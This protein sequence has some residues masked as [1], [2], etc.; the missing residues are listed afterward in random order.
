MNIDLIVQRVTQAISVLDAA[1]NNPRANPRTGAFYSP[2][3]PSMSESVFTKNLVTW[4]TNEHLED[5]DAGLSL[6]T[7]LPYPKWHGRGNCDVAIVDKAQNAVWAIEVKRI[8]FV[9]DNGKNNDFGLAKVLSPYNKDRSVV[10]DVHRLRSSK[11]AHHSAVVAYGFEY[12]FATCD[13]S[14]KRHPNETERITN[15]RDVCKKENATTGEYPLNPMLEMLNDFLVGKDLTQDMIV[16]DFEGAWKHP[17][18]GNGKVAGWHV[19]PTD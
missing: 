2:G 13:E 17:C 1:D 9:G 4:W 11:L 7:E 14:A 18:G 15:M 10:H 19:N 16:N 12:S 3:V 8:Q 6:V 5:I